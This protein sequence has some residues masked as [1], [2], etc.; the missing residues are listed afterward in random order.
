MTLGPY[1]LEV[2]LEVLQLLGLELVEDFLLLLLL[3]LVQADLL[4]EGVLIVFNQNVLCLNTRVQ[5]SFIFWRSISNKID[6]RVYV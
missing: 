1:F 3:V 6:V 4:L 5:Y 2:V